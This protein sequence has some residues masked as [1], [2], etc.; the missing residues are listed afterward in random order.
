MNLVSIAA[1]LALASASIVVAQATPLT[2]SPWK[3]DRFAISFW[4]DPI[5]PP[6]RFDAEYST[7]VSYGNNGVLSFVRRAAM[8]CIVASHHRHYQSIVFW[9]AYKFRGH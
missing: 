8:A 7:I 6:N 1:G 9:T 2:S 5:V 3:Q 4:V